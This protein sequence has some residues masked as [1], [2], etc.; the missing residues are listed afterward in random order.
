MKKRS[1]TVQSRK[2]TTVVIQMCPASYCPFSTNILGKSLICWS[3]L[4]L[5]TVPTHLESSQWECNMYSLRR[6]PELTIKN[7]LTLHRV[8]SSYFASVICA[9]ACF[10]PHSLS[11]I[12][13]LWCPSFFLPYYRYSLMCVYI[14]VCF[15]SLYVASCLSPNKPHTHSTISTS[16]SLRVIQPA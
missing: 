15:M 7:V 14:S 11:S 8:C 3:L 10:F 1:I 5:L 6:E 4:S 13:C 2:V 12:P 9:F 16:L